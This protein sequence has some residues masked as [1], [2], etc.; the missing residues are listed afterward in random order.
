MNRLKIN[1]QL[2]FY[3]EFCCVIKSLKIYKQTTL[4]KNHRRNFFCIL[5]AIWV[6]PNRD[7]LAN[8]DTLPVWFFSEVSASIGGMMLGRWGVLTSC[9]GAQTGSR[10]LHVDSRF[11][12]FSFFPA[13]NDETI[14]TAIPE[15]LGGG[16][17]AFY[18]PYYKNELRRRYLTSMVC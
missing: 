12:L 7:H 13:R 16:R 9:T 5:A 11:L 3:A 18:F 10:I 17:E 4:K 15:L 14:C 1:F 6:S 8:F 2:I